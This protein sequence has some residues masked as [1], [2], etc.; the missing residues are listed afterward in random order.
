M[1]FVI[2]GKDGS[3]EIRE[4]PSQEAADKYARQ[5]SQERN[6]VIDDTPWGLPLI[7]LRGDWDESL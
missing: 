4:F 2:E 5:K 6:D 7:S 1:K 3:R